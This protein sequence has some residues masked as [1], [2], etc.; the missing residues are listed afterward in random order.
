LSYGSVLNLRFS[1]FD[2]RSATPKAV[3]GT[4]C[5]SQIGNRK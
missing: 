5:K 3:D 4:N 1:I 2:L